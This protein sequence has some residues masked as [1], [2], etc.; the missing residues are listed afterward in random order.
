MGSI[1]LLT[2]DEEIALA[3]SIER[4]E[5]NLSGTAFK[6]YFAYQKILEIREL[7]QNEVLIYLSFLKP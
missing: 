6:T 3:S 1:P 5:E 7:H 4:A 2:H